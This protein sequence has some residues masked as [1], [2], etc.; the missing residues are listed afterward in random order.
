M[1]ISQR[2]ALIVAGKFCAVSN[3]DGVPP[4][5]GNR[6]ALTFEKGSVIDVIADD[7]DFYEVSSARLLVP[8]PTG[9]VCCTVQSEIWQECWVWTSKLCS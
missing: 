5:V 9:A 1:C 4:P 2:V 8:L 7:G 6:M 3:Y